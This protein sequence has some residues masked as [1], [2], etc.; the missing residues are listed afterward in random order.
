GR[1]L[2]DLGQLDDAVLAYQR[3]LALRPQ[4]EEC[5]DNLA[6]VFQVLGRYREASELYRQGVREGPNAA[7]AARFLALASLYDP[8]ADPL[9]TYAAQRRDEERFA[10]PA[11]AR[12]RPHGN[13]ADPE[14]PIRVAYLSSDLCDHPVG[15]NIEPLLAHRDRRSFVVAA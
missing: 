2:Y 9:T 1:T 7:N 13:T 14:R 12:A 10:R 11:Y 4:Y 5:R 6:Y 15:R 3:A 8:E